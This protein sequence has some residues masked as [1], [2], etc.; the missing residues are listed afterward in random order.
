MVGKKSGRALLREE[1]I[2]LQLYCAILR[3][4][5]FQAT[6]VNGHLTT[7][8]RSPDGFLQSAN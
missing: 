5:L 1:G 6:R 8:R 7:H 3:A 2:F 4:I